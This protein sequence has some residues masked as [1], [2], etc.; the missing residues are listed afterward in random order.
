MSPVWQPSWPWHTHTHSEWWSVQELGRQQMKGWERLSCLSS[1]VC[2]CVYVCRQRYTDDSTL[3][4]STHMGFK[5]ISPSILIKTKKKLIKHH[6]RST[7][8]QG[9]VKRLPLR[10]ISE[11]NLFPKAVNTRQEVDRA[12][13]NGKELKQVEI[14]ASTF[15][16]L[17]T[18]CQEPG[19]LQQVLGKPQCSKFFYY[20]LSC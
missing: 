2:V 11:V 17:L 8:V 18:G 4:S 3:H 20:E 15:L 12:R 10:G 1:I 19:G 5:G 6:M 16:P 9:F 7:A 14:V 13:D